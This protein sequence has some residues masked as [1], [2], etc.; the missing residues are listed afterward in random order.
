M[1]QC[2]CILAPGIG[3]G[4]IQLASKRRFQLV[5][6][7]PSHYNDDGYV[8]RWWRALIPSNSLAAVYGLALDSAQRKALGDDVEIDIDVIDETNTRVNVKKLINRFRK[9][10]NFGVLGLVGVQIES[11]SARARHRQ[12]VPRRRHSGRRWAASMS[13]A[14]SPCSTAPPSISILRASMG[15]SLFA[16]EAEGRFDDVPARRRGRAASSRSTTYMNDL[17]NLA[18]QPSPFLPR[19]YVR[20][21]AGTNAAFDAGRG[22][23]FQCSFCT[24][25]NVQGRKSRYRTPDDVEKIVRENWKQKH[26]ALLHDRRQFRAQQGMGTDLR[27]SDRNCARSTRFRSA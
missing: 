12:A 23:P 17:P 26:L 11:V 9:H 25:I 21:T 14:A 16:G 20:R 3:R 2:D 10:G 15:I 13:P 22:C 4:V 27:P 1:R 6:L 8:I 5:L 18:A 19:Q 7:K 24:I